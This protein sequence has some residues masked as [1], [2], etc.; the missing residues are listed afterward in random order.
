MLDSKYKTNI[1]SNE[2]SNFLKL[3]KLYLAFVCFTIFHFSEIG[4]TSFI[5]SHLCTYFDIAL[6]FITVV[7]CCYCAFLPLFVP[8]LQLMSLYMLCV[9]HLNLHSTS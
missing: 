5:L 2:C 9:V 4:L 1:L 7:Y 6:Y 8:F 3:K